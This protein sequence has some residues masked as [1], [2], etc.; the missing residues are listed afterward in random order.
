MATAYTP[1]RGTVNGRTIV[2]DVPS[3]LPDGQAVSVR[4]APVPPA[5]ADSLRLAFGSRAEEAGE[6]LAPFLREVRSGQD[7]DDV[8][9]RE[10]SPTAPR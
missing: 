7:G 2:L 1:I 10:A 4:L 5:G 3:G 8:T 6:E 9:E